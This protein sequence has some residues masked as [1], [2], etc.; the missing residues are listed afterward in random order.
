MILFSLKM[1][2]HKVTMAIDP[3]LLVEG[4]P[5]TWRGF[6]AGKDCS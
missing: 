6:H 4:V 2:Q 3:T 5:A 1:E